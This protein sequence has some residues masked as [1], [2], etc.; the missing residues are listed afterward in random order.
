M[1]RRDLL[2]GAAFSQAAPATAPPPGRLADGTI[3]DYSI[4]GGFLIDM[5]P[6]QARWIRDFIK[7][8]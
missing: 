7:A 4:L 1:T 6:E 2:R 3:Q 8:N 5:H